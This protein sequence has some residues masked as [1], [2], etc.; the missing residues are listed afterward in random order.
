MTSFAEV[1]ELYENLSL[2]IK[3]KHPCLKDWNV[4]WNNRLRNVMGRAVRK[5]DGRKYI[6]LS[7]EIVRLNINAP[8]FLGKIR[9]TI[10]HEWAH[11]LDWEKN[12][13]W[14]HGPTWRLWMVF[15]GI[16]PE[17][18]FDGKLWLVKPNK[19]EYAIRH[20]NGKIYNYY[21]KHP[22]E[23]Q[24]AGAKIWANGLRVPINQLSLINLQHGWSRALCA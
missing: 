14:G 18:C 8:N 21:P 16:R 13:C 24:I 11:A 7:T 4:K 15:L 1:A 10:L 6:E 5:G 22:T 9:E 20:D 2:E 3:Q 17:R 23:T 12:K 19:C